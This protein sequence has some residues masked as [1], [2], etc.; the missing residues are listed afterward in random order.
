ML[1][2][3]V[4]S[5]AN[6]ARFALLSPLELKLACISLR[7][8]DEGGKSTYMWDGRKTQREREREWGRE[9]EREKEIKK[10]IEKKGESIVKSRAAKYLFYPER[11]HVWNLK[12]GQTNSFATQ[13]TLSYFLA[14]FWWFV[15]SLLCMENCSPSIY[16]RGFLNFLSI[17]VKVL[18]YKDWQKIAEIYQTQNF[19]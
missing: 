10:E 14:I 13:D 15:A 7:K 17:C 11:Y 8:M 4:L 1:A 3:S 2:A 19:Q 18:H 9:K 12:N 16:E 6:P 5:Y